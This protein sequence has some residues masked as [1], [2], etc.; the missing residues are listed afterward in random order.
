MFNWLYPERTVA[1]NLSL[2]FIRAPLSDSDYES[3]L[4]AAALSA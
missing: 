2:P 4:L 1:G 3:S